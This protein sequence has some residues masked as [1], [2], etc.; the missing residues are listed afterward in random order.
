MKPSVVGLSG[1]HGTGKSTILS[2]VK[3]HSLA[4]RETS[5]SRT[6]Q[7]ELGW[8]TLEEAGKSESNM[9]ALQEAILSAMSQRD[10]AICST[11]EITLVD[12]TPADVWAYTHMWC[13]RLGINVEEYRRAQQFKES[14]F[15]ML[16]LYATVIVVPPIDSIPFI[17]E[18]N[19]ADLPSR[20]EV[21]SHIDAFI[22]ERDVP[23]III[24]EPLLDLRVTTV[25]QLMRSLNGDV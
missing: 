13:V 11:G 23:F 12:R 25:V 7:A 19:R 9:W 14:C 20:E 21:Q 17:A 6:A 16:Q 1:T 24:K 3:S 15:N 18:A 4:V 10:S 22:W 5:L 8:E 2:G